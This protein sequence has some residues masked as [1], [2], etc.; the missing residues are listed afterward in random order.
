MTPRVGNV[1]TIGGSDSSGCSGIQADV[2]AVSALGGHALVTVTAVT[3]QKTDRV[4]HIWEVPPE[5][6]EKQLLA[7]LDTGVAAVKTGMLPSPSVVELVAS[8]LS[9]RDLPIVVDP[10]IKSSSGHR[11]VKRGVPA[12]MRQVLFPLASLVTPNLAEAA[13]FSGVSI[14]QLGQGKSE[15]GFESSYPVNSSGGALGVVRGRRGSG[16]ERES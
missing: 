4:E 12:A 9:G 7:A 8:A 1:L 10:V 11:L 3:A 15:A 5:T 16:R 13:L 6:I 14:D 2:R